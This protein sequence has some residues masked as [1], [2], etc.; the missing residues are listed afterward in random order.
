MLFTYRA[1]PAASCGRSWYT[2]RMTVL[3]LRFAQMIVI[4][5]AFAALPLFAHAQSAD[6]TSTIRAALY[7]DPRTASMSQA[8]VDAM[9][10]ALS[11]RVQQKGLTPADITWRPIP[12]GGFA[13]VS[14]CGGYPAYFCTINTSFGFD[15]TDYM[16]PV[17]LAITSLLLIFL[18]A[19][20]RRTLPAAPTPVRM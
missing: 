12:Q 4:V 10:A 19:L 1:R 13:A 7:S 16:I 18:F 2:F 5:A 15:G 8:Q 6:L 3:P 11:Q 9:V 20:H 14:T 17:W